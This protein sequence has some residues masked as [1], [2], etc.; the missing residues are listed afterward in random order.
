MVKRIDA[1][2]DIFKQKL[3]GIFRPRAR[4]QRPRIAHPTAFHCPFRKRVAAERG[5]SG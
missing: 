2:R 5:S 1:G 4:D 3:I